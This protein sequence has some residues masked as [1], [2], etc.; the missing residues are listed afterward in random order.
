MQYKN[1][2]DTKEESK[3]NYNYKHFTQR[4]GGRSSSFILH[5]AKRHL[6]ESSIMRCQCHLLSLAHNQFPIHNLTTIYNN[7]LNKSISMFKKKQHNT[8]QNKKG[9]TAFAKLWCS[10]ASWACFLS[11][12][13]GFDYE[14]DLQVLLIC[15][16]FLYT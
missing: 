9:S 15:S 5:G 3:H 6:L 12:F 4:N 7:H 13:F 16:L 2:L 1:N 10:F 11:F 14:P 8:I